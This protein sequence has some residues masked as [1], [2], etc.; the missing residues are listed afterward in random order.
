MEKFVKTKDGRIVKLTQKIGVYAMTAK[1]NLPR[2]KECG[3]IEEARERKAEILAK[4][5]KFCGAKSYFLSEKNN[6]TNIRYIEL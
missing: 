4:G 2:F 3:S 1:R 5:W 6:I